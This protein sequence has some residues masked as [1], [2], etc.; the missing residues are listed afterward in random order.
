MPSPKRLSVAIFG[1]PNV[2]KSTLFNQLTGTRKAVVED[3]PGVTRDVHRGRADWRGVYFD[4]F[5]TAGVSAGGDQAWSSAIR[6]K[7]LEAASRADKIVFVLDGK[8]GLNPEDKDLAQFVKRLEKPILAVVNKIDDPSK[9]ELGLAEFYGLGLENLIAASFEHKFGT[10]DILDWIVADQE[11]VPQGEESNPV[12]LAIV[13]KPNAGKSTLVNTL[14]GEQRVVVSPVAGTTVDS[15]EVPFIHGDREYI[16][17]DTAGLRR[18]AKR[19]DYVELI[20]AFKAEESVAEADILLV[21]VDGLHGPSRQDARI[22]ELA[23][24]N[25]RGVIL[26][27]NKVDALEKQ[28]P[29]FR[30]RLREQIADSFHF[31]S[32]IPVV[33]ISAK[34]GRGV[35]E[36]FKKIEK[37]WGQLTFKISTRDINDFFFNV[38][39]QAPSPSFRGNDI[40][41]YYITQTKQRPPS[42]MMFVNEP[43]GVTTAY[44]RFIINKLKQHY[45]LEGIPIRIYPKKRRRGL[46]R[47]EEVSDGQ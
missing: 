1:R 30:E 17:V 7:A 47:A 16:L 22:V 21:V 15:V 35:D 25:H 32:D 43:K 6:E 26:V 42:F 41:F 4:V 24:E 34:T 44:R 46:A 11:A 40:K 38:I 36:L 18:H 28:V 20:S 13:G 5:D 3:R 10:D 45:D 12:K 33:F 19:Q 37:V 29:K 2:G 9:N 8:Y 27:I 14:L 39:R 31:Y 23:L